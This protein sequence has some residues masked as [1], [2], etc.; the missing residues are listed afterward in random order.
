[1]NIEDLSVE[2]ICKR[3]NIQTNLIDLQ[4]KNEKKRISALTTLA[5]ITKLTKRRDALYALCGYYLLEIENIDDI[6]LFFDAIRNLDSI[7]LLKLILKDI[8][9]DRNIF[10]RRVFIDDFLRKL[11]TSVIKA[12]EKDRNEIILLIENSVWGEKLKRKFLYHLDI[13]N[14]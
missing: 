13:E 7:E 4:S 9:E 2:E 6:E 11:S 10:R 12:D 5:T 8:S 1:M 3:I 14:F